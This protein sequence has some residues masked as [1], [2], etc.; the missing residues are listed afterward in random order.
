MSW[1]TDVAPKVKCYQNLNFTLTEMWQNLK[2]SSKLN[3]NQ[4]KIQEIGTD[5]HGLVFE[6]R[7][8][9]LTVDWK[10]DEVD[11]FQSPIFIC[12]LADPA[13]AEGLLYKHLRHSFI[14]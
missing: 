12:F 7:S 2:I 1:K 3:F 5:H 6:I 4:N 14:N 10:L 8:K 11:S 9:A 13:K